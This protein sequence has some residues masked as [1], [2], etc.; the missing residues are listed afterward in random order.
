M[1]INSYDKQN[2]QGVRLKRQ[3]F[4]NFREYALKS[5][6]LERYSQLIHPDNYVNEG[7][8]NRVYRIPDNPDFLLRVRKNPVQTQNL[9]LEPV[10]DAFPDLNVGQEIARLDENVAVV[11]AQNGEPC[12]IRHWAGREI[13][14]IQPEDKTQ[15]VRYISTIAGFP[16]KAYEDLV[17]EAQTVVKLRHIDI[18]NPQNILY[19]T[20]NK[21]FNIVDVTPKDK[22][23]RRMLSPLALATQLCDF[24]NL[25]SVLKM[26]D[27]QESELVLESVNSISRQVKQAS[28]N[29]GLKPSMQ[30]YLH[31]IYSLFKPEK[32][33]EV[34]EF[35]KFRSLYNGCTRD[36]SFDSL[37]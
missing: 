5:D 30:L 4:E 18:H 10:V 26:S 29:N 36:T 3:S 37:V 17:R 34:F 24:R 33:E 32:R 14:P 21:C 25:F 6:F 31:K 12:G 22:L 13:L 20:E 2:F 8:C 16:F 15:F 35:M 9:G 11:I 23:R 1:K 27:A 19:D 28:K 7:L